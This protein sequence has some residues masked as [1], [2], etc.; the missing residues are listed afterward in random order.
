MLKAIVPAVVLFAVLALPAKADPTKQQQAWIAEAS[1]GD[2]DGWF[3][4][5]LKGGPAER[6]FQHGWLLTQEIQRAMGEMAHQ[7]TRD[8]AM[9]WD[10]AVKRAEQMLVPKISPENLAEIDGISAGMAARGV[11]VSRAELVA[12]NAWFDLIWYWWPTYRKAHPNFEGDDK[13]HCSAFVATGSM[14]KDGKPLLAHNTHFDFTIAADFNLLIDVRPD[15]GHRFVMQGRP[16]WIHSGTDFFVTDAGIV[17][18]ETTIGGFESFDEKGTA[19]FDRARRAMQYANSLDDFVKIMKT[20]NNGG[21][22]NS[23]LLAD[24]KSGEIMR[25]ELGLRQAAVER[26]KDGY[27]SG[28]NIAYEPKLLA[29][30]TTSNPFDISTSSVA[31][32]ERWKKLMELNRGKIDAEIA[33]GM[34]GDD[35]DSFTA[36]TGPSH[37]TICARGDL[38]PGTAHST[39]FTPFNPGGAF[40]A[41]VVDATMAGKLSF[42]ASWGP[43]CGPDFNA[44]TF[45]AQHSQFD[46]LNGDLRDL[47]HHGWVV[48]G[49]K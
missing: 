20:G 25:F 21:Y 46:A 28:S 48:F 32:R 4:L 5:T 41:K 29:F 18:A 38:D 40:D 23:W 8:T 24:T 42:W 1:H 10:W 3:T 6:G 7:W 17:G 16:G 47:P 44:Q 2:Q 26:T 30:E 11:T 31:R 13:L 9:P 34:L 33:K 22:A 19:E 36:S 43:P 12:Y 49:G 15:K 27:Y 14:T 39:G 35:Y 45:L 37:R